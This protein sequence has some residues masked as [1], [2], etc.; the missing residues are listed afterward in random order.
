LNDGRSYFSTHVH[1][2]QRT[3]NPANG[4]QTQMVVDLES[5]YPD[6][7]DTT[8]N[9]YCVEELRARHRGW[10]NRDWRKSRAQ[11]AKSKQPEA[12]PT[13]VEPPEKVPIELEKPSKIQIFEDAEPSKPPTKKMSIFTDSETSK[14]PTKKMSIFEDVEPSRAPVKIPIFDDESAP[15][16]RPDGAKRK[17]RR[18]ERANRTRKL[19]ILEVKAEP[20]T[21]ESCVCF[22]ITV[23]NIVSSNESRFSI[24][25]ENTET[26]QIRRANYDH[27]HQRSD[28]RSIRSVQSNAHRCYDS[29]I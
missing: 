19:E 28:E 15:Q 11:V 20:Q 6:G 3:V 22:I 23:T 1:E 4:R 29:A 12:R 9:E 26:N 13:A 21:S 24:R 17:A 2:Q 10:L 18:E 14:P 25:S 7:D 27:Q 16:P 5:I 8:G